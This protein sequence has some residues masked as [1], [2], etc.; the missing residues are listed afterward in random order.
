MKS[1]GCEAIARFFGT[2]CC[3][4]D[5]G[6]SFVSD[7]AG[8]SGLTGYTIDEINSNYHNNLLEMADVQ[9][10]EC[11]REEIREQL[12]VFGTVEIVMPVFHKSGQLLWIMNRGQRIVSEDGQEYLTGVLVD[13]TTPLLV[14]V[15]PETASTYSA[16]FKGF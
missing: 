7:T 6:L 9:A 8:L 13:I 14:I 4:N 2:Y 12:A 1:F 10:Q 15:P 16:P 5:F 3:R 11:L